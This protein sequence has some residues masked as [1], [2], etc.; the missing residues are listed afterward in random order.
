[1]VPDVV[2]MRKMIEHE[3]EL[4]GRDVGTV[5]IALRVSARRS[6]IDAGLVRDR[7]QEYADAG[8]VRISFDVAWAVDSSEMEDRLSTL[9]SLAEAG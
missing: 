9:A 7:V 8:V 1:M 6:D 4:L 2:A 5:E 3:C